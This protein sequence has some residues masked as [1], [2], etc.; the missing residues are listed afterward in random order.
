MLSH[1]KSDLKKDL[2]RN[3]S[4]P[5]EKITMPN[6]GDNILSLILLA[7]VATAFVGAFFRF[8][9]NITV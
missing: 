3:F 5:R 1:L 4:G 9:N 8:D 6:W 7:N 2:V